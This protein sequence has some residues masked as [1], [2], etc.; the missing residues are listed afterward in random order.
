MALI[1]AHLHE[2]TREEYEILD[3]A[4]KTLVGS[5]NAPRL[6]IS[7]RQFAQ[8]GSAL[9]VTPLL[10]SSGLVSAPN[11]ADAQVAL[12]LAVFQGLLELVQ[13]I[14]QPN[15]QVQGS[16]IMVNRRRE[17]QTGGLLERVQHRQ[18]KNT[19]HQRVEDI[20]LNPGASR[21]T[22]RTK[23]PSRDGQFDY[24]LSTREDRVQQGFTVE[25]L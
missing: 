21:V 12:I 19:V 7:R 22:A 20:S 6:G 5:G 10:L 4:E 8:N 2:F 15:G 1:V 13:T 11:R 23:A 16:T 14:V 24:A 9:F 25:P 18:T 17:R 3:E